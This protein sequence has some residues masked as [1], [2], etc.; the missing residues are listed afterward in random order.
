MINVFQHTNR[1]RMRDPQAVI[2]EMV[3]LN[4]DHGVETF[5]FVDELFVLNRRHTKAIC[6][7]LIASG[8]GKKINSWCYCRPDYK[9]EVGELGLFRAAGFKWFALGIESGSAEVRDGADKSMSS[10]QIKAVVH[11]IEAAGIH[12]GANYIFGLPGETPETMEATLALAQELNTAWANFYPTQAFPGSK[13]YDDAVAAGWKP[14]PWEAFSMH[15][16]HTIPYVTGDLSPAAVLRARDQAFQAY[17]TSPRYLDSIAQR[18]G[19]EAR[20]HVKGMTSYKLKRNLL[21][22]VT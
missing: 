17:F 11:K 13:L 15:N 14:P 19:Q 8:L 6:E 3:M 2:D 10:E 21:E 9:F 7:R 18:F 20:K 16:E 12:I 4:R 22:D 5:K 1:Y